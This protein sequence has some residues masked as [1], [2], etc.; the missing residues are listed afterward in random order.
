MRK[1]IFL[2]LFLFASLILLSQKK[3][4]KQTL[5][6]LEDGIISGDLSALREISKYIDDTTFVQEFLGYHNYPNTARGVTM[7]I[8]EENCLFTEEELRIDSTLTTIRFLDILN[9]GKVKF[10][11]I[12]GMFLMTDLNHR[13]TDYILKEL[14]EHDLK[15]IDTTLIKA[16][17]P[18]WYYESQ[19]DG[20]LLTKNP[21]VLMQIASAWYKKRS[22]FNRY[23]F[24]DEEFLDLMRKLTNIDVGVPDEDN[25]VT[26]LYK[27]D[28]YAEAR[29][30][31]LIYWTNHYK[32][33]NWNSDRKYFENPKEGVVKKSQEEILF[34]LLNSEDDSVAIDAFAQLGELD[35]IRVAS[36]ADEYQKGI[37]NHNF[38]LPTFPFRFLKQMTLLTEYCRK[39]GIKY[40][41]D[42]WLLDSLIKL[43]KKLLYN[44][45]YRI[46]NNIINSLTANEA[47]AVE[48]FGLVYGGNWDLTF[49]IGRI[50]DKFYSKNWKQLCSNKGDL[51]S[52]L[53]KSALFDRLGIIGICN[54]YLRKFENCSSTIIDNI[55]EIV[56]S[57]S[58]LDVKQQSNEVISKYSFPIEAKLKNFESWEGS[59]SKYGA[60]DLT[61]RYK[62]I[63][64]SN[65]KEDDKENEIQK[66][67]GEISYNQLFE[68]ISLLLPDTAMD[69]YGRFHFIESDF[70]FD[71]QIYD[72][73]ELEKFLDIYSSRSEYKVYEYYLN[74]A[75]MNCFTKSDS[76]DYPNIYENLKYNVIDAFVGG[77]GGRKDDG[78]YL[79]I[80]LLEL[81]FKT[82]LGFPKKLCS[83]QGSYGCDC[84][85]RAKAWM[86]FLE[87][88]KLVV[89]DKSEP[90]SISNND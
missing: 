88:R 37:G 79:I 21:E 16:P 39:N 6:K 85:D 3:D 63:K 71:I 9:N 33:Y 47:T 69:T 42:N 45:R 80:K 30:N 24:E 77:G 31:Y 49:S 89:P 41:A 44:E 76:L 54:K 51:E 1:P 58:D 82:T 87:E 73:L 78:V 7:R 53:K 4:L 65:K 38:S 35:P 8:I 66:L 72:S 20:F 59:N 52:F 26:F 36:L 75:G 43:K 50:L 57:T 18:E 13:K 11:E 25:K 10:D 23:Y 5:Y 12:T 83:W 74:Q 27:G 32:D 40:S 34:S 62:A 90:P 68:A 48:Y 61:N 17:Y 15:R 81:K 46:E 19:I 2:I 60:N 70:G 86:N 64:K 84:E 14:S 29:L 28:Y 67:I 56:R 55:K 22:R